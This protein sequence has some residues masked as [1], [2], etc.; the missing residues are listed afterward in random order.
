MLDAQ[1]DKDEAEEGLDAD[2]AE[3][4]RQREAEEWRLKQLRSG[5]SSQE[6]SN[7][8]VGRS[9]SFPEAA[10]RRPTQ[11]TYFQKCVSTCMRVCST[12]A[13]RQAS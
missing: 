3:R 2:A 13:L 5:V 11:R 12:M 7:F 10:P 9:R 4:R 6:N 1:E 8:Q